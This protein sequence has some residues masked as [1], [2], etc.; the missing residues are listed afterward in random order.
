M[1][2][3]FFVSQNRIRT[4]KSSASDRNENA[5]KGNSSSICVCWELREKREKKNHTQPKRWHEKSIS[6]MLLIRQCNKLLIGFVYETV[7]VAAEVSE[8]DEEGENVLRR[9]DEWHR[10]NIFSIKSMKII[11]ERPKDEK[12]SA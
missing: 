6:V 4:C 9:Y 3:C 10:V 11:E 8:G 7:A 2:F 5:K 1:F 12:L